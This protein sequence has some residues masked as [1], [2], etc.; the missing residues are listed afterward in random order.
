MEQYV[1]VLGSPLPK[2]LCPVIL[3]ITRMYGSG[4]RAYDDDNLFA[5]AKQ[6]IDCLKTPSARSRRGLSVIVDDN[7]KNCRIE[8]YQQKSDDKISKILIEVMAKS[9]S[10]AKV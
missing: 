3:R 4:K 6:T 7:P 2:F 1:W 9:Y 10:D 5:S 8:M